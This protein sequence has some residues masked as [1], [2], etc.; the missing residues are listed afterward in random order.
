MIKTYK[1]FKFYFLLQLLLTHFSA[2]SEETPI[3][4]ISDHV[5]C[6]VHLKEIRP[7]T[8]SKL[9]K[10]YTDYLMNNKR[11]I[12]VQLENYLCYFGKI[13]NEN[14]SNLPKKEQQ[15]FIYS[16]DAPLGDIKTILVAF[17]KDDIYEEFL[18]ER[19]HEDK[20]FFESFVI[21]ETKFGYFHLANIT[22][23]ELFS[24]RRLG[25][26]FLQWKKEFPVHSA[27]KKKAD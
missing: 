26:G 18:A 19:K 9:L 21:Y 15:F 2:F 27:Q 25:D 8:Y 3:T 1:F 22:P 6:F 10:V 12:N 17:Q 14:T 23:W 5:D 16:T 7:A 11:E 13:N 20:L 24:P 4:K